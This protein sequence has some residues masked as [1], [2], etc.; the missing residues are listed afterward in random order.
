MLSAPYWFPVLSEDFTPKRQLFPPLDLLVHYVWPVDAI[1]TGIRH[2]VF[3]GS[4]TLPLQLDALPMVALLAAGLWGGIAAWRL[5]GGDRLARTAWVFSLAVTLLV[6]LGKPLDVSLLGPLPWRFIYVARL[7][8]ALAAIGLLAK[9]PGAS[10]AA[11]PGREPRRAVGLLLAMALSGLFWGWPLVRHVPQADGR[12]MSEV[13]AL[14]QWLRAHPT[15]GR[16]YVQDTFMAAPV[17]AELARSHVLALSHQETGQDTLAPHYGMIPAATRRALAS[18]FGVLFGA[19]PSPTAH[20]QLLDR[21]RRFG[22]ERIVTATVSSAAML[23][24]TG[25]FRKQAQLGRFSVFDVQAAALPP[26]PASAHTFVPAPG[27]LTATVVG[28]GSATL[29]HAFHRFWRLAEAP[30][31]ARLTAD[32]VGLMKVVGLPPG[33]RILRLEYAPPRAPWLLCLAGL[34]ASLILGRA[35]APRRP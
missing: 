31:G 6:V 12:E 14:W 28:P 29:A 22:V 19:R 27:I 34:A 2:R 35:R 20:A 5:R 3:T 1:D 16:V 13:R 4:A 15:S 33:R 24:R 21:T 32:D 10:P 11:A 23:E 7:G 30:E 18:E 8:L 9:G 25:A 26:G 17:E